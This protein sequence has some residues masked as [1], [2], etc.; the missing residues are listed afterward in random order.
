MVV[1]QSELQL[2][3][4][5]QVLRGDYDISIPRVPFVASVEDEVILELD[6]VA[7]GQ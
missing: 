5:T 7:V 2:S 6:L 1:S 4:S 3:G